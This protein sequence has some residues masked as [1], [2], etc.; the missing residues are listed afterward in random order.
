[1]LAPAGPVTRGLRRGLRRV[2]AGTREALALWIGTRL[3]LAAFTLLASYVLG[4]DAGGRLQGP[5]AWALE[6]FTWWDS[7]QFLRTAERGYIPPEAPCC[8]Q[9]FFPGYPI[10]M[11]VFGPLAGGN[12]AL[13]GVI[14]S[15]VAG[16]AAACVLWHLAAR[17]TGSAAG[18][19]TAVLLLAAAPYGIFLSAVYTEALFL[20]L[21]LGAWLAG[22]HRRW[23]LAGL[24]AGLAT[25]VRIN[26]LFLAA[27]LA[28]MYLLQLHA[29]RG[30]RPASATRRAGPTAWGGR[31]VLRAREVTRLRPRADALGLLASPLAVLAYFAHLRGLT[32]SWNAWREAEE[33]GWSRRTAWPWQGLAEGW[34]SIRTAGSPDLVVSRW[35]DLLVTLFGIA[36]VVVLVRLRR[37]A[38]AA[39]VLPNVL[40]LVCSTTL[41]SA[42]R[43]AL[44][45]FP[46][47][48]LAAEQLERPGR[49]W[50]RPALLVACLPL[51]GVVTLSFSAHLWTA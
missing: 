2:P 28:V 16:C 32:G 11:R 34:E 49:R 35:A 25:G 15:F 47:Y 4:L 1:M 5:G 50:W 23:W 38:E 51:L 44:L 43:Y 22:L 27:A 8:S 30:A 10:A 29:D 18:G 3:A 41:V 42:P 19:R 46:A 13:A 12:L 7:F 17:V 21:A 14:V 48:L 45:W 39:Y 9:A 26:G 40:V 36:L 20:A 6:R 24:L 31:L 37:W 33:R